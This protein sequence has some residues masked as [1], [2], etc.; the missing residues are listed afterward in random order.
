MIVD[1]KKL[2]KELVNVIE[3]GSSSVNGLVIDSHLSHYL[4]PKYVDLCIVTKCELGGLKK[5]LE[6]RGYSDTKVKENLDA[7]IFN[8]CFEE[9][10][11]F[12]HKI[13][14][15]DTSHGID[16]NLLKLVKI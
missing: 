2:N 3:M 15:V 5:R 8:V 7:E 11:K 4:P 10:N 13:L 16:K 1:T 9:A 6:K 14:I 12:G